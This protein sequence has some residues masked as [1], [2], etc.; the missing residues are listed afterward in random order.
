MLF[1]HMPAILVALIPIIIVECWVATHSFKTTWKAVWP[2]ITKANLISMLVG[3]PVMWI[4]ILVVNIAIG[5]G[6]ARGLDTTAQKIYAVTVQAAWLIPYEEHLYW[7]V[8]CAA[9]VMLVPAYF[10]SVFIERYFLKRAWTDYQPSDVHRFSWRSHL[11]S[12][13]ILVLLWLGALLFDLHKRS[14]KTETTATPA[15]TTKG[16]Q[17]GC[18]QRLGWHLSCH[19]RFPLAVA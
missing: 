2:A 10:M 15:T 14:H 17:N 19:R 5:G 11:A 4:L 12:Y 9:I 18:R 16:E 13:S 3:F 6:S 8:P 7:M 1:L